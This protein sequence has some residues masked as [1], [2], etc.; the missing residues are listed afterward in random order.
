MEKTD[1]VIGIATATMIKAARLVPLL[2]NSMNLMNKI[3]GYW[4]DTDGEFDGYV[5]EVKM[6]LKNMNEV[7]ND[8]TNLLTRAMEV[9]REEPFDDD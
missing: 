4:E 8:L 1:A 7:Y 3:D 5:K 2:D 9:E 6:K